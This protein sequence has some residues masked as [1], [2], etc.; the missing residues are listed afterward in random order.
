MDQGKPQTTTNLPHGLNDTA[1]LQQTRAAAA[2]APR[3]KAVYASRDTSLYVTTENK[4]LEALKHYVPS[5]PKPTLRLGG[6]AMA[7][8]GLVPSLFAFPSSKV[9]I[10]GFPATGAHWQSFI[11]TLICGVAYTIIRKIN[12]Y[13]QAQKKY[14]EELKLNPEAAFLKGLQAE[15][16]FSDDEASGSRFQ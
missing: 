10:E 2:F 9:L 5:Q 13:L 3:M 1:N 4:L 11:G 15:T 12:R 14:K 6:E 16:I 7:F 8:L